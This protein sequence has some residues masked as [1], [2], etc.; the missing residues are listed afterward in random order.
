MNKADERAKMVACMEYIA[1]Q[2]N[3]E[4]V[5]E[6]WLMCGVA[7]SDIKYGNLDISE[8]DNYYLD[9]VNFKNLMSTFLVCMNNAFKDGGL[10]CG[11][12]VSKDKS[13]YKNKE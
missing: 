6:T 2:I 1:R 9:D 12:V 7:D 13:D 8:I 10:Y 4:D 5:F 11:G 3:N